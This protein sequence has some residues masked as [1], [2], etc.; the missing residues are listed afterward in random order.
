M[1]M[2][3]I[4]RLLDEAIGVAVK[5]QVLVLGE[6]LSGY[7]MALMVLIGQLL[8]SDAV[9]AEELSRGFEGALAQLTPENAKSGSGVVLRQLIEGLSQRP[10]QRH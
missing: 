9:N 4:S 6:M 7:N 10:R 3:E 5:K 2:D 1:D 8:H